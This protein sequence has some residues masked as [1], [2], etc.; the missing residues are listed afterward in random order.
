MKNLE[1]F[2]EEYKKKLSAYDMAMNSIHFDIATMAPKNGVPHANEMMSILAGEHFEYSTNPKNI[3]KIELLYK[4]TK[5]ELLKKEL[6]L[7]LR[8]LHQISK[9]PKDVYVDFE[10]AVA[11]SQ[12]CWEQARAEENYE[13]F[14]P[15]LLGLIEKSKKKL[16]YFE[17]DGS[18]YD[19][20]LDQFQ[21]GMDTK[22]YDLFFNEVKTRLVPFIKRL[23]K[24]G[25]PIDDSK[26][27]QTFDIDKQQAFTEV[28][29]E[30]LKVNGDECYLTESV[31]P[32]TSFFSSNDCRITTKY[33]PNSL[34]SAVLSTVHEYGH[35]LYGL[36]INKQFEGT[37]FADGVGFAMHES[38]SRLMENHIGKNEGFWNVLYP[39]LKTIY[40]GVFDDISLSDFIKMINV[41]NPSLIRV[42]AD[43]LTY[44]L[45]ILVRY[46]LEKAIFDENLNTD[47]LDV[48]WADKYEEYL[49]IRPTTYTEGILQDMHWG[50]AYFGY[51]PSYA[52]GSAFAAQFYHQLEKDIDVD[53]VLAEDKFDV[54][55][56][57]LKTNI[58]Q[59]GASKTFN[60]LLKDVTGEQ[61]N[62]SYYIDYLIDKYSKLYQL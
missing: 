30:S 33:L 10:K 56:D 54:V 16:T 21:I 12:H 18:D 7:R 29:K 49:G 36:Q 4:E 31:H 37:M 42:E 6:K 34:M 26:L 22:S 62:P 25:T 48:L 11:D 55:A 5:D 61:F 15:H 50:A 59:Y 27:F 60:E 40:P 39:K 1:L 14:K 41:T 23:Q 57:W 32:F 13:L 45:H 2:Y 43:E 46:E 52:L 20:L 9:L 35:A 47:N 58:H 53:K 8:D 38:Q 19:F 51:F 17:K 44:P 28:L 24:E 3:E